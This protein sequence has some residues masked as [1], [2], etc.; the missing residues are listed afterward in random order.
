MASNVAEEIAPLDWI[1]AL[2]Q[3][4]TVLDILSHNHPPSLLQI[5]L[6]RECL[7]SISLPH[8]KLHAVIEVQERS[9]Y[10]EGCVTRRTMYHATLIYGR[11]A[12]ARLYKIAIL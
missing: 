9:R 11:L 4:P 8:Q 5:P 3:D 7:H 12:G 2:S 1:N 6:I 10:G